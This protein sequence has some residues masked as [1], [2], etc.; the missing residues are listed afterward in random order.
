MW[1][2]ICLSCVC[3][4]G[5]DSRP[6]RNQSYDPLAAGTLRMCVCVWMCVCVSFAHYSVS[7]TDPSHSPNPLLEDIGFA[8]PHLFRKWHSIIRFCKYL[9]RS[10][11]LADVSTRPCFR[12]SHRLPRQSC[13]Y[14]WHWL[15]VTFPSI[16]SQCCHIETVPRPR[17]R[18]LQMKMGH[19]STH[20]EIGRASCRESV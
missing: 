17:R 10:I 16:P 1:F 5:V 20:G 8:R 12:P 13:H 15:L 6:I 4:C 11:S 19:P 9:F 7:I 18:W 2:V 3:V 14:W